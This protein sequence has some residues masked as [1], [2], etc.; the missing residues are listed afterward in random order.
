MSRWQRLCSPPSC[1]LDFVVVRVLLS[2]D[3]LKCLSF[4]AAN[5]TYCVVLHIHRPQILPLASVSGEVQWEEME[6]SRGSSTTVG[7]GSDLG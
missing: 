5:F 7:R 6:T 1:H 2:C 3:N 4:A